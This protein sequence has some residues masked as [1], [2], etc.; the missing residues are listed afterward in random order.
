MFH[1]AAGDISLRNL[2]IQNVRSKRFFS[3]TMPS[4]VDVDAGELRL[5]NVAVANSASPIS[6]LHARVT[7]SSFSDN[8]GSALSIAG[9]GF[10]RDTHFRDNEGGLSLH[11]G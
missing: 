3:R 2:R 9:I 4:V 6:T 8:T 5:D 1:V 11:G 10:V 7:A